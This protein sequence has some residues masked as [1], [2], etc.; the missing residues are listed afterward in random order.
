MTDRWIAQQNI[1]R[2]R[3]QLKQALTDDAR[4]AIEKMLADEEAKLKAID[5]A[6]A[7]PKR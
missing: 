4:H 7:D 3:Q 2:F 5:R 1:V 6:G